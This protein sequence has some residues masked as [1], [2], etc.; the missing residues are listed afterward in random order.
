MLHGSEVRASV[1]RLHI[2]LQKASCCS[3][4]SR[5][6]TTQPYQ[7]QSTERETVALLDLFEHARGCRSMFVGGST[8]YSWVAFV[9]LVNHVSDHNSSDGRPQRDQTAIKLYCQCAPSL[10]LVSQDH[11][12]F[13]AY[14]RSKPT[15]WTCRELSFRLG[16]EWSAWKAT[17]SVFEVDCQAAAQS[18]AHGFR[19]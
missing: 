15:R 4:R 5:M 6:T 1:G 12:P 17:S 8:P 7:R 14:G 11:D 3:T 9:P 13:G 16:H 18:P 19:A 10:R 2:T